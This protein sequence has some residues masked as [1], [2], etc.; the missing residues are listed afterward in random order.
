M[1]ELKTAFCSIE[2]LQNASSPIFVAPLISTFIREGKLRNVVESIPLLNDSSG[3]IS[4]SNFM[5]FC[6]LMLL[7]EKKPFMIIID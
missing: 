5:K 6:H 3:I 4:V 7:G 1:H 2:Q